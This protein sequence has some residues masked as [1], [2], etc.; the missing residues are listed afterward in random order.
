MTL[1]SSPRPRTIQEQAAE[2]LMA[3]TPQSIQAA[4]RQMLAERNALTA[5]FGIVF[6]PFR[7]GQI[8][9]ERSL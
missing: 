4:R 5:E 8:Q 1:T 9:H 7:D 6:D 3:P 2:K